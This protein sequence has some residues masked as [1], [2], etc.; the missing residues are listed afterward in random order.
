MEG[1]RTFQIYMPQNYNISP[2]YPN[3]THNKVTFYM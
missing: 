2:N 1:Q 3:L